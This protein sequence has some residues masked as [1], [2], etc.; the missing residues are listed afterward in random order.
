MKKS[1]FA[2]FALLLLLATSCSYPSYLPPAASADKNPYGAYIQL[3]SKTG[4]RK[5]GELIASDPGNVYIL[6]S[7]E[8]HGARKCIKVPVSEIQSYKVRVVRPVNYTTAAILLPL[9]TPFMHGLF[10]IFSLPLNLLV[11]GAV[12]A[13]SHNSFV[14]NETKVP[15]NQLFRYARYPGGIPEGIELSM[16]R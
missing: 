4:D 1:L 7:I 10:S 14:F 15:I 16:I 9:A 11:T 13:S 8:Y 12:A 5:N 3:K 6:T 2:S